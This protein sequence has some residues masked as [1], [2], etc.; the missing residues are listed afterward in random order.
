MR[1]WLLNAIKGLTLT[2]EALGYVLGRGLLSSLVKELKIGVWQVQETRAPDAEFHVNGVMGH[3]LQGMLCIPIYSPRGVLLGCEFRS[4]EEKLV[5]K[6][7]LPDVKWNP[8][9]IG[10]CPSVFEKICKGYD[11][12]LVEGVFDLSILKALPKNHVCLG[13]GGARVTPTQVKF[14]QRFVRPK[15]TVH[16]CFD[17]DETGRKLSA[18]YKNDDGK[19]I[20]GLKQKL[21]TVH[22]NTRLVTY[23]GGKDP[24]EIWESGGTLALKK[25]FNL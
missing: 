23:F 10:M 8:A 3:R 22:I 4:M 12:W 14:L 6:Y 1:D 9:F 18:G 25:S 15:S 21:D 17:M 2:E 20:W 5:R 19:L 11:V 16:I 13:M 7:Y 24:G